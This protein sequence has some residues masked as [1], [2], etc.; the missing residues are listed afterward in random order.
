M[1][2]ERGAVI[3]VNLN[4]TQGREQQGET[5]PCLVLSHTKFND[6]RNGLVIISPITS[7]VKPE[8]KTLVL[9]PN[10]FK[11][12]GSVMAEQVR[13]LDLLDR[14]WRDTGEVLPQDFVDRVVDVFE[15]IIK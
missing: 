9:V 12:Q 4:P 6:A 2:L 11:V 15:L 5:R 1:V 14:W 8:V 3:R 10:G 13:A 7:T